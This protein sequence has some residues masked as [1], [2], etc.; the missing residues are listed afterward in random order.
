[1]ALTRAKLHT[2][3]PFWRQIENYG[4]I[5]CLVQP[6]TGSHISYK[7][8]LSASDELSCTLYRRSQKSLV[9][10]PDDLTI[11]TVVHLVAAFRAGHA[12]HLFRRTLPADM[13]SRLISLYNPEYFIKKIDP[14]DYRI[15]EFHENWPAGEI[16]PDLRMILSTS[17]ST[18]SSKMVQLS[19]Y[20]LQ[21]SADQ[22]INALG[23][24][25]NIRSMLNMPMSYVYGF[26]ILNSVLSA[27]GCVV[28]DPGSFLDR[29][30][31]ERFTAVR[32]NE[33]HGV[34]ASFDLLRQAW[35]KGLRLP[36]LARATQS[37]GALSPALCQWLASD[38]SSAG[39]EVFK[40][41]GL[42]EAASRVSVVPPADLA[43]KSGSVGRPVPG[44]HLHISKTGEVIYHGPN[45]MM[46]YAAGRADLAKGDRLNG[47]LVTGDAGFLDADG[48]LYLQG[49][50]DRTVKING[51][52]LNLDELEHRLG[53]HGEVGVSFVN[54]KLIIA[55]CQAN[56]LSTQTRELVRTIGLGPTQFRLLSV[57]ALPRLANGKLDYNALSGI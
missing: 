38:L 13:M 9:F 16:H 34:P 43:S 12:I 1:M 22:I 7:E 3:L 48:F 32:A 30:F 35:I 45:V 53:K 14:V 40:M 21:S 33:I 46:G 4:D 27:G 51:L 31:W 47:V 44:G 19:N 52:R 25:S 36:T 28:L 23:V 5:P 42:T 26:S 20:N 11:S 39:V 17:G 15:L 56:D 24:T 57:G 50:A 6:L 29:A 18:G 8:L 41:Y 55:C 54:D 49:R 10:F 2:S 37:G